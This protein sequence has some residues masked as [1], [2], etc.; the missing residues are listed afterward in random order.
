M[1]RSQLSRCV[2]DRNLLKV[3]A[4]FFEDQP[5]AIVSTTQLIAAAG[6]VTLCIKRC[7]HNTIHVSFRIVNDRRIVAI[8]LQSILQSLGV[9]LQRERTYHYSK[10]FQS[11]AVQDRK[12]TRLNSSHAN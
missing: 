4:L 3:H 12:S 11:R 7:S 1:D 2:Y 8:T 6:S 9:G 5:S 10:S